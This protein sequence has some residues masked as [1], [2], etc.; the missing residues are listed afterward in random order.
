MGVVGESDAAKVLDS[1]YSMALD[2]VPKMSR[3]VDQLAHD[4]LTKADNPAKAAHSLAM[5]QI[6][7]CGTSGFVSGL[8]GVLTLPI[9]LPANVTSVLY[10]QM[11]M[12]AAIAKIGGYDIRSDQV[13]TLAYICLTG[14]SV[15][16][17]LADSG[18]KI[19]QKTLTAT[20][21]KIPGQALVKINQKVGYR[22][23]TKFG[24]KG[25]I[26]LGKM[27]PIAG[28]VIGGSIDCAS[29][30]VIAQNAIKVFIQN[31]N[32]D[33]QEEVVEVDFVDVVVDDDSE[34]LQ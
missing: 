25:V 33:G 22:L 12:I 26:N 16:R 24:E 34:L 21:A 20:I 9:A 8:G 27:V 17:V 11:R 13:K 7:K 2:G 4:Y 23:L 5:M 31:E 3:S 15:T 1:L 28:G 14:H 10:I 29:T 18:M 32:P 30:F 19:G 6:A